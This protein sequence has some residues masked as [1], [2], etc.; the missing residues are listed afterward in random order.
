MARVQVIFPDRTAL[1]V[2]QDLVLGRDNFKGVVD[3]ENLDLISKKHFRI[4]LQGEIFF[5]EDGHMGRPSSNG[6]KL[7]GKEIAGR[8]AQ[9]L[10][11]GDRVQVGGVV[12]LNLKMVD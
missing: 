3:E 11:D 9:P 12:E 4:F 2:D 7:N 8:G 5:I 6:T 1:Y 10:R